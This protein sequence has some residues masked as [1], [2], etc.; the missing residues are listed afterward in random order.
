MKLEHGWVTVSKLKIDFA[1]IPLEGGF[2]EIGKVLWYYFE[3][4][5]TDGFELGEVVLTVELEG[6][7]HDTA[8]VEGC[9]DEGLQVFRISYTCW[10]VRFIL[11]TAH[12]KKSN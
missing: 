1:H 3:K 11:N 10:S 12:K 2:V 9:D 7:V 5:V 8:V 4:L 6:T